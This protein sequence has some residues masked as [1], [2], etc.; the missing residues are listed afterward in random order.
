M[1]HDVDVSINPSLQLVGALLLLLVLAS[2]ASWLGR[3][4]FVP[5]LLRAGARAVVQLLAVSFIVVAAISHVWSSALFVLA[6]FIVAVYTTVRRV[7]STRT[8][9][10]SALAMAAGVLPVLLIVFLT[11]T[12][13]FDGYALLPI[14]SIIV[15]NMM[16]AHTLGGRRAFPELR[17]GISTYE[18]A[19]S[20]GFP[21]RDAI[22]LV[23]EPIRGE[24]LVPSI[25]STR[26]VGVV[27][28]PG[29][30]VGVL[31]GGGT[32]LQAG[33]SQM[34]VVFGILAGQ[35]V[36]IVT[37]DALIERALLLP[38]DLKERLRP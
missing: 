30:F 22:R 23:L 21:R 13:P 35:A 17:A 14:G 5:A 24:A 6:M 1:G 7:E 36:T 3:W 9:Q 2:V 4:G 19:L 37:M 27:T 38:P 11:G 25:D 15:G 29:A 8:W 28:L 18:A 16:T 32:P 34:L 33:A 10:W 26:T 31:L 20:L 12:A